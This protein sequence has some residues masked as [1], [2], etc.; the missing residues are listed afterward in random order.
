[1]KLTF[2]SPTW[3]CNFSFPVHTCRNNE[4]ICYNPVIVLS[5][6]GCKRT[7]LIDDYFLSAARE[8]H[9]TRRVLLRF[10]VVEPSV[11]AAFHQPA[12][13]ATSNYISNVLL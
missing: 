4:T 1:M 7:H 10:D 9:Q 2:F 11:G 5:N 13:H 6:T 8:M 12:L 3:A